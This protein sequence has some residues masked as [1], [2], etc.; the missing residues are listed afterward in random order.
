MD[1]DYFFAQDLAGNTHKVHVNQR[2]GIDRDAVDGRDM[3]Q[4]PSRYALDDGSQVKRIDSD[5]FQ[6]A[7]TGAFITIVRD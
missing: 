7:G 6:I 4:A 5:T 1:N 2:H 3:A